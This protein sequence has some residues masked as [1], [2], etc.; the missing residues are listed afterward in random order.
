MCFCLDPIKSY[1]HADIK[2]TI[3]F[4]LPYKVERYQ[5]AWPGSKKRPT[6]TCKE[7]EE[8]CVVTI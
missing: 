4:T 3:Y 2:Q 7:T 5:C 8:V 1:A 6:K